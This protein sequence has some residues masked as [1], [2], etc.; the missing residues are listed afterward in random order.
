MMRGTGLLTV[1]VLIAA[2]MT[3]AV[4]A[5][6]GISPKIGTLGYGADLTV[7]VLPTVNGR[8]GYNTFSYKIEDTEEEEG[9]EVAELEAELNLKTI[10]ALLDWHP[11]ASG[12]RFTAGGMVNDNEITLTA[13][14]GATVDIG[15]AAYTVERVDGAVTF[16]S[17]APYLGI[18]VGNAADR[19]SRIH[20][21]LDFGALYQGPPKVSIEATASD[22]Q[23]QEEL[24]ADLD[25]EAQDLE[26]DFS[27]FKFYPV[28]AFGFSVTF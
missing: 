22:P 19:N 23:V 2:G 25:Q 7:G 17:F 27:W 28:I 20:F 13:R 3:P 8:L 4:H 18:G 10:A 26:D 11:G 24:N 5:G 6:V 21:S 12:F 1:V 9:E 14:P 15:D 16:D